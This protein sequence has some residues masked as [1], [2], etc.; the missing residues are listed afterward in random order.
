[1]VKALAICMVYNMEHFNPSVHTQK[2]KYF[3]R[4]F[5][6]QILFFPGQM[7][8]HTQGVETQTA[9]VLY[10]YNSCCISKFLK[11]KAWKSLQNG[12]NNMRECV[13][14]ANRVILSCH[15]IFQEFSRT[16]FHFQVLSRPGNCHYKNQVHSRISR[17]RKSPVYS[18]N[19][20]RK[21]FAN[22]GYVLK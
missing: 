3:F 11:K 1:M 14:F 8:C 17:M 2:V 16:F 10:V 20:T 7:L 12:M 15:F 19:I 6:G 4:S 21:N 13:I 9:I 18:G 22:N 5:S